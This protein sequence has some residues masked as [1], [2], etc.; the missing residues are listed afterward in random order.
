MVKGLATSALEFVEKFVKK[1]PSPAAGQTHIK[2]E[3]KD[4]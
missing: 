1:S 4:K 2:K 3:K